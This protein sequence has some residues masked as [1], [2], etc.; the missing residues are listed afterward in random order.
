VKVSLP[1]VIV[2]GQSKRVSLHE[3][4]STM[5]EGLGHAGQEKVVHCQLLPSHVHGGGT[6]V[7]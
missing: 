4:P 3:S 1:H 6:S 7:Q 2:A 5:L